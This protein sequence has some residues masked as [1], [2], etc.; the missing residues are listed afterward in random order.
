MKLESKLVVFYLGL[1]KSEK[2][3][4][5]SI[6]GVRNFERICSKADFKEFNDEIN[7]LNL[8]DSLRS[9]KGG[10]FDLAIMQV[11]RHIVE[12]S[13][14]NIEIAESI[15]NISGKKI[16]RPEKRSKTELQGILLE[17]LLNAPKRKLVVMRDELLNKVAWDNKRKENGTNLD[18]WFSIILGR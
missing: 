4:F 2:K 15:E 8:P 1:N 14:S 18:R 9:T 6:V 7:K 11:V 13:S 17:E 10:D 3:K 12:S 16:T 5:Q